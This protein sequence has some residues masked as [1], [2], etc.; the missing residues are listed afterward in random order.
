MSGPLDHHGDPD[1]GSKGRTGSPKKLKPEEQYEAELIAEFVLTHDPR[2]REKIIERH[3]GLAHYIAAKFKNRGVP[4]DDLV[5]VASVAL[6][7]S[8]DRFDPDQGAR[9]GTYAMRCILGEIK[10]YFR[11]QTWAIKP[12]RPVQE[13]YLALG[14]CIDELTQA[15]GHQ[16]TVAELAEKTG[17]TP[18]AVLEAIEAGS[19]YRASS[20]D[21]PDYNDSPL[22]ESFGS[23]DRDLLNLEDRVILPKALSSLESTKRLILELYYFEGLPQSVIASRFG[24]SQMDISRKLRSILAELRKSFID[25]A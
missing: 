14:L 16:P 19:C 17:A 25:A 1:D 6:V 4:L 7:A 20:L 11:D 3:L 12:L 10:R 8:F 15:N 24:V 2:L 9:F 13:L 18:D 23:E 22:V 21:V 5:Q